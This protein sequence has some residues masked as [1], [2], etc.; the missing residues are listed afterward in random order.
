MTE[1]QIARAASGSA[2][3]VFPLTDAWS[4][5]GDF[6]LQAIDLN[7]D[8]VLD[9]AFGAVLGTPNLT[10]DYWAVDPRR[11][12]LAPLGKLTNLSVDLATHELRT[13]EKGGH[14]GLLQES[15]AYRWEDGKLSLVRVT[16]QSD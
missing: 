2:P 4:P 13:H 11:A 14:A 10:L 5:A 1:L 8:G 7:F 16:S 3:Q 6:L 12:A 15:K 9:L